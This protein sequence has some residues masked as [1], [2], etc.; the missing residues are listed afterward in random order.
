M[1]CVMPGLHRARD[2][3]GGYFVSLVRVV[4]FVCAR[5]GEAM[6]GGGRGGKQGR[7]E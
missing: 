1:A 7:A 5:E 6:G 4:W 2:T 3:L